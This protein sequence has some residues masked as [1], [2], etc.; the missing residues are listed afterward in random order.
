MSTNRFESLDGLR[1]AAAC[2]VVIFHFL[3]AFSPHIVPDLSASL[4]WWSDSPLALVFNGGFAVHV[5]FVLSGFVLAHSAQLNS[6]HLPS[7]LIARYVRL[8]GPALVSV[9]MAWGLLSTLPQE[10]DRFGEHTPGAWLQ[11][12]HQTSIPSFWDAFKHG[13]YGVFISGSSQF[14]NVLWTMQ[15]ELLGSAGVYIFFRLVRGHVF[16]PLCTLIV[17]LMATDV[18]NAFLGFAFGVMIFSFRHDFEVLQSKSTWLIL[19]ALV[20]GSLSTGFSQRHGLDGW[21]VYLQPGNKAGFWH[22]FFAGLLVLGVVLNRKASE[23][24]GL[25]AFTYLGKI[26]FSA[27]LLH[28]PLIY[29]LCLHAANVMH[30]RSFEWVAIIFPVYLML[31]FWGAVFFE[32]WV[33][34]PV[35][36]LTRRIKKW[37]FGMRDSPGAAP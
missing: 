18:S 26:S 22:P 23:V 30:D 33:D 3:C 8:A 36:T 35:V 15:A 4:P 5:F 19:V 32:R 20:M 17:I 1:G 31:V 11:W 28:V 16:L 10:A 34:R 21:P 7:A 37:H 6:V 25:P 9:L 12:T 13:L 24:L 29:T 14:N 2:V 27:Y